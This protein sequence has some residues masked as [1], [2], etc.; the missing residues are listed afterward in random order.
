M[1]Q[2]EFLAQ[3]AAVD[4]DRD[5]GILRRL[6]VILDG[7]KPDVN[8]LPLLVYRLAEC[9]DWD[10]EEQA[11]SWTAQVLDSCS[12]DFTKCQYSLFKFVVFEFTVGSTM[13]ARQLLDIMDCR[14]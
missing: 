8:R 10:N 13:I 4:I 9:L 5:S 3:G 2:A 6:P 14:R 12:C 1:A 11:I 7:C